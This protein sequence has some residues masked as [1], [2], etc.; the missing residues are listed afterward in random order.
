MN[1]ADKDQRTPS[2]ESEVPVASRVQIL[3]TEHWSL[4]STCGLTWNEMFSRASMFFTILSAS[5]VALALVAQA[6][7]FG[8]N[9]RLVALL[10]LSAVLMIGIFSFVRISHANRFDALLVVGM[11]RLRRGYLDIAPELE[12]YFI[13]GVRDDEPGVRMTYGIPEFGTAHVLASSPFHVGAVV[14]IVAAALAGLIAEVLGASQLVYTAA[15]LIVGALG[16]VLAA[17]QS[18]REIDRFYRELDTRFPG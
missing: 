4:L 15:G 12:P 2:A 7:G 3:A 8:D 1:D 9:F 11:N 13:T 16:I 14:A 18:K 5:V 10:L 6:G 17:F